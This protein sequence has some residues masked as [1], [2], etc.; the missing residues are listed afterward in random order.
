VSRW[1]IISHLHSCRLNLFAIIIY[2]DSLFFPRS[3]LTGYALALQ[4]LVLLYMS[5]TLSYDFYIREFLCIFMG[6]FYDLYRLFLRIWW[7][8]LNIKTVFFLERVR[9]SRSNFR[10]Y[11]VMA[12]M[13]LCLELNYW[14]RGMHCLV[15]SFLE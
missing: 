6:F 1:Q 14:I 12:R 11:S 4:V 9:R 5:P 7:Q 2:R 10:L 13:P 8:I 3:F 15:C